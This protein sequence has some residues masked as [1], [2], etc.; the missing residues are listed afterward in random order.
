MG[1]GGLQ[2]GLWRG[3]GGSGRVS[4]GG[5]QV[6]RFGGYMP[7]KKPKVGQ[8]QASLPALANLTLTFAKAGSAMPAMILRL[9]KIMAAF[10]TSLLS[11]LDPNT[12]SNPSLGVELGSPS[13][14]NQAWFYNPLKSLGWS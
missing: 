2:E 14:W 13:W 3:G 6:G 10:A 11:I 5:L 7:P 1:G 9:N 8:S 12:N 4:C